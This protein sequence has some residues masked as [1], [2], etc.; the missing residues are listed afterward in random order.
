MQ[1]ITTQKHD[2]VFKS[3]GKEKP[4]KHPVNL[5]TSNC[6][7]DD[8]TVNRMSY[9]PVNRPERAIPFYPKEEFEMPRGRFTRKYESSLPLP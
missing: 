9:R 3:G 1:D 8:N 5:V 7:M 6:P 4:F 2:Y